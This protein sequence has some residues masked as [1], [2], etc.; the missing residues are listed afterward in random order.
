MTR[1]YGLK[2]HAALVMN[3][4]EQT[5]DSGPSSVKG[6]RAR[7]FVR[8]HD[9][10][11]PART[12]RAGAAA[13]GLNESASQPTGD[14]LQKVLAAAG[15]GSRRNCEELIRA[16]RVE[17]DRRVVRELGT[18][19]AADRQEIRVDGT[20]I[21]VSRK[22]YFLV[23]KPP[24]VVSTSH[25]PSGRPLVLDLL[26]AGRERLFTVGR[27]DL[28]SE[29]LML[30]TND[31]ELANRLAHPRYGVEKTYQVLV[32]G[33]PDRDVLHKLRHGIRLAEGEA[34]VLSARM[35]R[36][37]A[38]STQLELVLG[39]GRNREIR[40]MLA[41]CGHKVLRLKRVAIG[42]VRLGDLKPGD[43]RPARADEIRL[44][45]K[46]GKRRR[47]MMRTAETSADSGEGVE[48][49]DATSKT[50]T[51]KT[52]TAN[53][54]AG[55]SGRRMVGSTRTSRGGERRSRRQTVGRARTGRSATAGAR[56]AGK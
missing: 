18:R 30:V 14:R 41:R 35:T 37:L 29:G 24:G 43:F 33:T 32:A 46:G 39:E 11:R 17:V 10:R 13:E 9:G 34:R 36:A 21:T 3:R 5:Q 25:D 31:G 23:N 55:N 53:T 15:L 16:G 8:R 22:V 38:H 1:T 45:K 54:V 42:D 28:S 7:H 2:F 48:L 27:L 6:R 12:V 26:P 49:F 20:P 4:R 40:R 44:L 19:V 52:A 56:S 51:A 50:A 47:K